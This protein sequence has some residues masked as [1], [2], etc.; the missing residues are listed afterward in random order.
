MASAPAESAVDLLSKSWAAIVTY[1]HL[2]HEINKGN[3]NDVFRAHLVDLDTFGVLVELDEDGTLIGSVGE[4]MA[5]II[6]EG[7]QPEIGV[8]VDP[9]QEIYD[10]IVTMLEDMGVVRRYEATHQSAN[11]GSPAMMLRQDDTT[12]TL[13]NEDGF[14][15]T[16][17]RGDW[18]EVES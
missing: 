4:V 18:D 16:D 8:L 13:V 9:A 14:E 2:T 10:A 6:D 12:I 5:R 7:R 11:D 1:R 3:G 15:W 17:P